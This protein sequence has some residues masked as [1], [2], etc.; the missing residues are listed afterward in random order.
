MI[1]KSAKDAFVE[2]SNE[3]KD[4]MAKEEEEHEADI[5]RARLEAPR[6]PLLLQL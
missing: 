6:P 4:Y 3:F 1:P 2:H 5:K